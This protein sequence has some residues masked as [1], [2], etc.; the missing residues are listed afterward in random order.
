MIKWSVED[1]LLFAEFSCAIKLIQTVIEIIERSFYFGFNSN[2]DQWGV[3][4][5]RATYIFLSNFCLVTAVTSWMHHCI[6]FCRLNNVEN[7]S[8]HV[9]QTLRNTVDNS[10]LVKR[11]LTL[12]CVLTGLYN[13]KIGLSCDW[14]ITV[15]TN[16]R[17]LLASWYLHQERSFWGSGLFLISSV[18]FTQ[19]M[20]SFILNLEI[21]KTWSPVA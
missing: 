9:P 17:L 19:I 18:I 5:T 7:Y 6:Y 10:I 1:F 12:K 16:L 3:I 13:L 14:L 21:R 11:S 20:I 2:W 15:T 8:E 4:L